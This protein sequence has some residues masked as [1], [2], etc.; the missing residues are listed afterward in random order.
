MLVLHMSKDGIWG[1]QVEIQASA[2]YLGLPINELMYDSATSWHKQ[3][4]FK[5]CHIES[6]TKAIMPQPHFPFTTNHIELLHSQY[7]YD[8]IVFS[9][10]CK[11]SVPVLNIV[12]I[13]IDW[14][15]PLS[16]IFSTTY[17]YMNFTCA[18]GNPLKS[19]TVGINLYH[20]VCTS[21]KVL[22]STQ[23]YRYYWKVENNI[24]STLLYKLLLCTFEITGFWINHFPW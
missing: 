12:V 10:S 1:T 24:P 15:N 16:V 19:P 8:S 18:L 9:N 2:D 11:L 3:I 14:F 17:G 13:Q 23:N 22:A 6:L 7:H 4:A 5:P 20:Q 21:I